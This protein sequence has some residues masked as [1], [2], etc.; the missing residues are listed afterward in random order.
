MTEKVVKAWFEVDE[1]MWRLYVAYNTN[2]DE[3][4]IYHLDFMSRKQ[5]AFDI[6][7]IVGMTSK[8]LFEYVGR[9][10]IHTKEC[11]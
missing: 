4:R 11:A 5:P 8:E 3:K 10:W 6:C 2:P 9:M 7:K 1:E